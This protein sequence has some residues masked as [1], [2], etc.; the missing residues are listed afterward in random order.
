MSCTVRGKPKSG[1]TWKTVRTAK[2]SAIKKDK[3]IRTSF[4]TRRKIEAEIK[5]IRNESIERKKAKNELKK[6]KRLKEEEKRQRKL[7][8]ERRSEIVVPITNPAKIKRLRKKQMRTI[9]TR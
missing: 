8:N 6:A 7:E 5:K 1:R 9:V 4:Q 2:H 3:G